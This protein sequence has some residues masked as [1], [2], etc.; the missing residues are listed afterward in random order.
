MI[1]L[2]SDRRYFLPLDSP[3]SSGVM[4]WIFSKA[5][6]LEKINGKW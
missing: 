5:T 2:S 4:G 3:A 1:N 6:Q